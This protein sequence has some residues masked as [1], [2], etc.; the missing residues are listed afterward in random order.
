MESLP[1]TLFLSSQKFSQGL[2]KMMNW[3]FS[4][5]K[6]KVWKFCLTDRRK[7]PG[8]SRG[9]DRWR[10]VCLTESGLFTKTE[11]EQEAKCVWNCIC[12]LI[13]SLVNLSM[14]L[15]I[16]ASTFQPHSTHCGAFFISSEP[17]QKS[18]VSMGFGTCCWLGTVFTTGWWFP[19]PRHDLWRPLCQEIARS[20]YATA[21]IGRD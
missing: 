10:H 18:R 21:I 14:S 20:S 19:V 3:T 9:A 11:L 8:K 7:S 16:M 1:L 17:T 15:F 6:D 13:V 2:R 5:R 4:D 12:L